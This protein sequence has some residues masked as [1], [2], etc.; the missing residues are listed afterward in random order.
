VRA[1]LRAHRI[2][3]AGRS[4]R[5][6]QRRLPAVERTVDEGADLHETVHGGDTE[7][8]VDRIPAGKIQRYAELFGAAG[9]LRV[10]APEPSRVRHLGADLVES[11]AA[12]VGCRHGTPGSRRSR[13]TIPSRTWSQYRPQFEFEKAFFRTV[14]EN[15]RERLVVQITAP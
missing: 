2:A 3:R 6:R 1:D 14:E 10:D 11:R 7:R 9:D 15:L 12:R 4:D 5:T 8:H 13:L